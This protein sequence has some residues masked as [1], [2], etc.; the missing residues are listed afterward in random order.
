MITQ[1]VKSLGV[2]KNRMLL[3]CWRSEETQE[4]PQAILPYL[5]T[6]GTNQTITHVMKKTRVTSSSVNKIIILD[7]REKSHAI[8]AFCEHKSLFKV[9]LETQ[10]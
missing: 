2:H 3:G 4:L 5:A 7:A 10:P 9:Q 8:K 6:L 1:A